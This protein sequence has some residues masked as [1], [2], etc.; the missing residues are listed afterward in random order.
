MQREGVIGGKV[1]NDGRR[2]HVALC[3]AS[4][5][6]SEGFSKINISALIDELEKSGV[7][8]IRRGNMCAFYA[9]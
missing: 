7:E 4:F 2:L 8:M 1:Y 5:L 9:S 3:Q 6:P